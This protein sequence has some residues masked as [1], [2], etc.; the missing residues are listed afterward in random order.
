M[1][2]LTPTVKMY[3]HDVRK[4]QEGILVNSDVVLTAQNNNKFI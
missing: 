3:K 4:Y 1:R 2:I